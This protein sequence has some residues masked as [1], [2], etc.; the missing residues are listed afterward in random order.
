MGRGFRQD[1]YGEA[2]RFHI[3][4]GHCRLKQQ[5]RLHVLATRFARALHDKSPSKNAEGAGKAGWPLHPGPRAKEIC[6]SAR[7]T[8]TGGDHTGLPCAMVYGLYVIS[9]VNRRLPPSP[10]RSLWSF[11]RTWRLHGRART[12]RL[13]RPHP[14][15]SSHGT[16]PSTAFRT[17]FV[18]TRTPLHQRGT[19]TSKH[20]FGKNE[21]RIFLRAR[22]DT[23]FVE[24]TRRANHFARDCRV[25]FLLDRPGVAYLGLKAVIDPSGPI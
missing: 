23:K 14:C 19:G 7:T 10:V 13:R 4:H 22:V 5:P 6:A 24:L 15:R 3:K 9:P 16:D 11:A 12:T 25:S 2:S 8:G 17:T 1:D 18:T 21:R 20:S